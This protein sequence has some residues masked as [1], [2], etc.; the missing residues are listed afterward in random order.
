MESRSCKLCGSEYFVQSKYSNKKYCDYKCRF[1]SL[2]PASFGDECFEWP[3][4][5]NVVTGYGQMNTSESRCQLVS[6]HRISYELYNGPIPQG[7]LVRHQCDNR[8]CVN[9]RHL[10]VGTQEDNM[11]DM[12]AR[13]RQ[14]DYTNLPK[15]D[16][17]PA[18]RKPEN[19]C[20]GERHHSSKLTPD[21][22]KAIRASNLS[23]IKLAKLYGVSQSSILCIKNRVTWKHV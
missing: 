20:R 17:N 13:G 5:R 23:A 1:K 7:R 9:P 15:G 19:L 8:A 12:W 10:E 18:R 21:K 6:T 14:Q 2:M 4:S 3:K 11:K 22:V 16:L